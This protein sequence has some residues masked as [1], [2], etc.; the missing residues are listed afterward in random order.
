[1]TTFIGPIYRFYSHFSFV[2]HIC[3]CFSFFPFSLSTGG[4]SSEIS[5]Y[6]TEISSTYPLLQQCKNKTK[7][8]TKKNES[9]TQPIRIKNPTCVTPYYDTMLRVFVYWPRYFGLK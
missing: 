8:T 6:G 3:H 7:K 9:H 1:M 5:L 2:A 4:I